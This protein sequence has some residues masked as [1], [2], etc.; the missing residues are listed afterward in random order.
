MDM[1]A[2]FWLVLLVLLL[3]LEAATLGLTTIWFAG[4]ALAAFVASLAKADLLVQVILFLA[5]SVL[6]LV[7]TRPAA[8]RWLEQKKT[9]TNAGSLIGDTGVVTESIDNLQSRGQ[10]QVRGQIWTARSVADEVRIPEGSR[11]KIEQISGVK[12]MV[13]EER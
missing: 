7:F 13:K 9:R 5:V 6:L 10:V 12:L 2:V 11:V 1:E 3:I 8:R 4:G